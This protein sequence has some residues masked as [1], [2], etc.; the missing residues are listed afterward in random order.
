MGLIQHRTGCKEQCDFQYRVVNH[1]HQCRRQSQRRHQRNTENDIRQIRYCR[2][3][4]SSLDMRCPQSNCGTE[5][6]GDSCC[7]QHHILC[8]G[9]HQKIRAKAVIRQTDDGKDTGFYDSYRMKQRCNRCRRYRCFRQPAIQRE[10]CRFDTKT[11]ECGNKYQLQCGF[12][13]CHQNRIEHPTRHKV[14]GCTIA[15]HKYKA[16]ERQCRTEHHVKNIHLSGVSCL[17]VHGV[18]NQRQCNQCQKFIE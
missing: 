6:N 8:H 3:R 1:V 15:V 9:A 18:H 7:H 4:K 11:E 5:H 17:V 16:D 2:I 12:M 10:N 14:D 13:P